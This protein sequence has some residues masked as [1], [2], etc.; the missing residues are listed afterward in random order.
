MN[1]RFFL[2][3]VEK[4]TETISI[5]LESRNNQYLKNVVGALLISEIIRNTRTNPKCFSFLNS[6]KTLM[7]SNNNKSK[8]Y[9]MS[10]VIIFD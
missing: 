6:L 4:L 8:I 10:F 1:L 3:S 7:I 9:L 2:L 5:G